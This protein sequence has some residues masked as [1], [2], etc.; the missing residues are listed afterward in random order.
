M[1][2]PGLQL[3]AVRCGDPQATGPFPT[4]E[5]WPDWHDPTQLFRKTPR[6]PGI[7]TRRISWAKRYAPLAEKSRVRTNDLKI[8]A[9]RLA[10]RDSQQDQMLKTVLRQGILPYYTFFRLCNQV[11]CELS[12][13]DLFRKRVTSAQ[14]IIPIPGQIEC[15]GKD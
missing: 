7:S 9:L 8:E 4:A 1:P 5:R 10:S 3:A 15:S 11:F 6:C 14:R 2:Q 13:S 12:P